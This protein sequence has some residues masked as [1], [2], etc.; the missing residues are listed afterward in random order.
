[1][2]S[3]KNMDT[4]KDKVTPKT[5]KKRTLTVPI[6]LLF[7]LMVAGS[8]PGCSQSLRLIPAEIR[9]KYATTDPKYKNVKRIEKEIIDHRTLY[10]IL[11]ANE[12][13]GEEFNFSFFVDSAGE[14][15]IHFKNKPQVA[16]EKQEYLTTTLQIHKSG[17]KLNCLNITGV[18]KMTSNA[19]SRKL[20]NSAGHWV[21]L[22]QQLQQYLKA[23]LHERFI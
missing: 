20:T 4:R 10:T 23:I 1:M 22:E 12:S 16:W 5:E 19:N 9:G 17:T 21:T 11:C 6:F 13:E 8:I 15:I 14:G 7:S 3:G 18:L 2:F